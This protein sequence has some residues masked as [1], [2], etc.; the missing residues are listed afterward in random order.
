MKMRAC[1]LF[2]SWA[3]L[4][5]VVLAA[6]P[7][8]D[9]ETE[10]FTD[11][12]ELE[13]LITSPEDGAATTGGSIDVSG[14]ARIGG[15]NPS[16]DTVVAVAMDL[17]GSTQDPSGGSCG[18]LNGD[19]DSNTILDCQIAAIEALEQAAIGLATIAEFGVSVFGTVAFG[20]DM[21]PASGRQRLTTPGADLDN[22]GRTDVTDVVRSVSVGR[23]TSSVRQFTRYNMFNLTNFGSG[24]RSA[25]NTLNTSSQPN[26]I[27]VFISDGFAFGGDD[28]RDETCAGDPTIYAIA[29]GNNSAC[30]QDPEN[31][32]SLNDIVA[33]GA[34][35]ECFEVTQADQLPDFLGSVLA[36]EIT[37]LTVSVNGGAEVDISTA[38]TTPLPA[39]GPITVDWSTTIDG[40]SGSD[41]EICITAYGTNNGETQ[42]STE[43]V[44]VGG[45]NPPTAEAG[46]D[47]AVS[48]GALVTLD[49]TAS[50]DPD[51]DPL[52]YAWELTSVTGQPPVISASTEPVLSFLAFD[53]ASYEFTL[54]VDDGRSSASDTVVVNVANE[55]PVLSAAA[56]PATAG[57]VS[58]L[59]ASFTDAGLL[60]THTA[61]INW[62]D[63][64]IDDVAVS[65]QGNGWGTLFG[66]HI[67]G[68]TGDYTATVTVTD[69]DG[70]VAVAESVSIT[71]SAALAL[72]ADGSDGIDWTGGGGVVTGLTHSNG[73][74]RTRGQTKTFDGPVEYVTSWN[75]KKTTTTQPPTQVSASD[76]PVAFDIADYQPGGRAAIDAGANFFDM[77]N[78]CGNR[79]Q[80]SGPLTPGL[81]WVPCDV[82]LNSSAL[83]GEVTIVSTDDIQVSG[84]AANF[85]PFIDGLLFYSDSTGNK[86]IKNSV[87]GSTFLGFM[88]APQGRVD[89]K[90]SGNTYLCGIVADR[91]NISDNAIAITAV[92]CV[93]PNDTVAPPSLVPSL[94]TTVTV[95]PDTA[96]PGDTLTTT[97]TA[98]NDGALLFVPGVVGIENLG[99]DAVTINDVTVGIEY[100]PVGGTDWLPI[101]GTISVDAIANDHPSVTYGAPFVNTWVGAGGL[102]SWGVQLEAELDAATV[103]LLLD[104]TQ[105]QAV[106][107]TFDVDLF[108]PT[109]E[110][111]RR[112]FRYG[113]DFSD[114]LRALSGDLT[115]STVYVALPDG[116]TE[117]VDAA[118]EPALGLIAPGETATVE[119]TSIVPV[120]APRG[121]DEPSQAYVD[122]L[123]GLNDTALTGSAYAVSTGGVGSVLGGFTFDQATRVLPVVTKTLDGPAALVAGDVDTFDVNWTNVGSAPASTVTAAANVAGA[124]VALTDA[125]AALTAGEIAQ[126]LFDIAIDNDAPVGL[127]PVDA[128]TGWTDANG[129]AY[130]DVTAEAVVEVASAPD[131][132]AMMADAVAVDADGSGVPSIGDTIGYS[133]TITN[134]GATPADDVVFDVSLDLNSTLDANSVVASQ[135]TLGG[136]GN[137]VVVDVGTVAPMSSVEITF[138]AVATGGSTLSAQGTVTSSD[139]DPV[140]TDDPGFVGAFDPTVTTLIVSEPELVASLSGRLGVD[141][142]GDG[143]SADDTLV[144]ELL[145][146]NT[147]LTNATTVEVVVP[148]DPNTTLV[149]G[150][151]ALDGPGQI[152]TG[153]DAG[154]TEI[155][156]DVGTVPSFSFVEVTFEATVNDGLPEGETEISVQA[157]ATRD[158]D[159]TGVVSDDPAVPGTQDPTVF[160]VTVSTDP[161]N[162]GGG[163]GEDPPG[164][165]GPGNTWGD[166]AG[167]GA[168]TPTSNQIVSA[169]VDVTAQV[170]PPPDTEV[171]TWTVTAFP[172]GGEPETGLVLAEGEGAPPAALAS[173]DPTVLSN[174]VWTIRIEASDDDGGMG[175]HEVNVVVDG[176]LKLGRFSTTWLGLGDQCVRYSGAGV[177]HL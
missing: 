68:S 57:G 109:G 142:D 159:A 158:G 5:T 164:D 165:A 1:S 170:T 43:C 132:I 70:A 160:T 94:A 135:G 18:N 54:T 13:L 92:D 12:T 81:Y 168:V 134:R 27:I 35:G 45:N 72:W 46:P 34:G 24:F 2:V 41:N 77:S 140:L 50:S 17:S 61:T 169:P 49:G 39:R 73:G 162:G 38:S 79:W 99:V 10:T 20:A 83:S 108:N 22:N 14:T 15:G 74:I 80:P 176:Q 150:S 84:S 19:G 113:N 16:P 26:R 151:V 93:R 167:F 91:I 71:A 121:A 117:I 136:V 104:D 100:L 102:A 123:L 65:G 141:P 173:F 28:V 87:S 30:D 107:N 8:A 155:R 129:N 25:C 137:N 138:E 157:T 23:R 7:T 110:P 172:A 145:V 75:V 88:Y 21:Q 48:E 55:A 4:A 37:Q 97:V 76:A 44:T 67:Y 166:D 122:R 144:Y 95:A 156:I 161:G 112:L 124:P 152:I 11:G 133:V 175:V 96:I 36:P 101:P 128:A 177:A 127:I 126:G 139:T 63:G 51:G 32:G 69:D 103:A 58:V 153:N 115:D 60:D 114:A 78:E 111:V 125:P 56:E 130:G 105:V 33:L 174:G 171:E 89:L 40:L 163:D 9:A 42:S 119:L 62:G 31:L 118:V 149:A 53:D 106:R 6:P 52:T 143:A 86:A 59:T 85:A 90:G 154:D 146:T 64:T 82:K 98:T 29:V 3:V 147:G 120:P 116:T 131:L 47:Q 148:I 66:S